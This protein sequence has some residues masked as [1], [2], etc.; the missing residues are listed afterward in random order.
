M[1]QLKV[2]L[3][4]QVV[5]KEHW[6]VASCPPLDIFSQGGTRREAEENLLEALQLFFVSCY[7]RDV[8]SAVLKDCGF[9]PT[10]VIPEKTQDR[11]DYMDVPLNLDIAGTPCHA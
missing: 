11:P 10:S 8:L 3:P 5:Q 1:V 2:S 9:A 7:E 6:F 4:F